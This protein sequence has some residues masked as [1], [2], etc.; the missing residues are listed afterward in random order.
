VDKPVG[1]T[2]HD[3]VA[4]VR[5]AAGTRRVGHAGTLDP[6]ASGL[7]AVLVGR[8]T[9]LM[10]YLVGLPK[11]Y[12]GTIRLGVVTDTD[13]REGTVVQEDPAWGDV[14][15]STLAA[16]M[17]ALTGTQHQR[18]PAYSAK[19]VA[20]TAAHRRARRGQVV[21]LPPQEV[22]VRRFACTGRDGPDVHFVADVSSGTYVRALAR[23]LGERLGCGAHLFALRRT[24]I[25]PFVEGGAVPASALAPPLSLRPPRDAVPHLPTR[26][27]TPD[28]L[29]GVRHGRTVTLADGAPAEPTALLDG[30]RLVAIGVPRDGLL[31]PRVVLDD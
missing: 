20:G 11:T 21:T 19:K 31:Q 29:A 10:P 15:V 22:E 8:A 13:D 12:T 24:T 4:A 6:F 17:A 1:P 30:D 26:S 16:G 9:R 25:G 2:S 27:L 5:R 18:P 14:T 28:E 3:I 23:D 7:L